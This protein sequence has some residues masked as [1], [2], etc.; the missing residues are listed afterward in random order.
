M[1][2]SKNKAEYYLEV[3][4][5]QYNALLFNS[6]ICLELINYNLLVKFIVP[7]Y[8]KEKCSTSTLSSF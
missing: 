5:L 8:L 7:L 3:L 6:K 2:A 4:F 1:T